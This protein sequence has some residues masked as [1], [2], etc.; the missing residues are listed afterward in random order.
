[1]AV[2][3]VSSKKCC[4]IS[5]TKGKMPRKGREN[6]SRSACAQEPFPCMSWTGSQS[7]LAVPGFI[8]NTSVE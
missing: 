2:V 8:E 4:Q 3:K 1:M 7:G 6:N 5:L